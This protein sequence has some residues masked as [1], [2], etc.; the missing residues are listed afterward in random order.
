MLITGHLHLSQVYTYFFIFIPVRVKYNIP[1]FIVDNFLSSSYYA[2]I[3]LFL[4][5][6][7]SIF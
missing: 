5:Y 2:F 3:F 4:L 7:V 6:P 1:A